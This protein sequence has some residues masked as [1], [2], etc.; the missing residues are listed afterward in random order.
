M[1]LGGY[2]AAR[3]DLEH[4]ASEQRREYQETKELRQVELNEVAAIFRGYGLEGPVLDQVTAARF[5]RK[6]LGRFHDAV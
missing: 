4:Y 3:T 1:G 6:A 5:R 2:L